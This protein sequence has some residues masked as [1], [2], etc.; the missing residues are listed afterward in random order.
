[1]LP[2]PSA[3]VGAPTDARRFACPGAIAAG[4]SGR[5]RGGGGGK[6]SWGTREAV[7]EAVAGGGPA[8]VA[9]ALSGS[10]GGVRT[11]WREI[12]SEASSAAA[13]S[14]PWGAV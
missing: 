9:S 7:R 3:A 12:T 6:K 4:S 10:G 11:R 1:M 2:A 5:L 8:R 14:E 13:P